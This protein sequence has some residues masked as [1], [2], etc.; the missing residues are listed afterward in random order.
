MLLSFLSHESKYFW[1]FPRWSS[2]LDSALS[3]LWP[4]VQFL[5]REVRSRKPHNVAKKEGGKSNYFCTD[6]MKFLWF[7]SFLS[8][9]LFFIQK[10][11]T[12][13]ERRLIRRKSILKLWGNLFLGKGS[14]FSLHIP[15]WC[16]FTT[17]IYMF[18]F[19][20]NMDFFFSFAILRSVL[21]EDH[22][23]WA[24]SNNIIY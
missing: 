13:W 15:Y 18:I 23:P 22:V 21:S 2:G 9:K 10:D 7:L 1:E 6:E 8:C 4:G 12:Y 17:M 14:C 20:F 3:L 19:S 24:A 11:N 16:S 5:V